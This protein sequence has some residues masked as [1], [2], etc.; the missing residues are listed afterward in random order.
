MSVFFLTGCRVSA[1]TGASVG[2]LET[3]GVE[4]DLHATFVRKE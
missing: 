1:V 3:E 4:H 2:H